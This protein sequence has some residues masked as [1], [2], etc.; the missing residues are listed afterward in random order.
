MDC[1]GR[2]WGGV[3]LSHRACSSSSMWLSRT[4]ILCYLETN[5]C[6]WQVA[7]RM[8]VVKLRNFCGTSLPSALSYTSRE[9]PFPLL[10]FV[11]VS[12]DNLCIL[13]LCCGSLWLPHSPFVWTEHLSIPPAAPP[14][15]SLPGLGVRKCSPLSP[16]QA[17]HPQ[18]GLFEKDREKMWQLRLEWMEHGKG[19]STWTRCP[20]PE[21]FPPQASPRWCCVWGQLDFFC[22][23]AFRGQSSLWEELNRHAVCLGSENSLDVC[24]S[25]VFFNFKCLFLPLMELCSEQYLVLSVTEQTEL[26]W[27]KDP[28]NTRVIF[29]YSQV[30]LW[31][32]IVETTSCIFVRD[33]WHLEVK[34]CHLKETVGVPLFLEDSIYHFL[35]PAIAFICAVHT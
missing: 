21:T 20:I 34:L 31:W 24:G 12:P 27:G 5:P 22:V 10:S 11:A 25:C 26:L 16:Y 14:S 29:C 19:L 4:W 8:C 15:R 3:E 17:A 2:G 32:K 13:K 18:P 23:R 1:F 9:G 28:V 30:W 7:L 6:S 33:I 35:L